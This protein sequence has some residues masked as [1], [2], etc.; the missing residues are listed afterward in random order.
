MDPAMVWVPEGDHKFSPMPTLNTHISLSGSRKRAYSTKP[1]KKSVPSSATWWWRHVCSCNFYQTTH[2][3]VYHTAVLCCF[4]FYV[5]IQRRCQCLDYIASM[6][7][8]LIIA[9]HLL[10]WELAGET[11]VLRRKP[12]K[13]KW[14]CCHTRCERI[15]HWAHP[16]P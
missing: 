9:E 15:S 6:T 14:L 5:F 12:P 10:E 16:I 11:E 4:F 8:W 2:Y 1:I 13:C 7:G 3:T